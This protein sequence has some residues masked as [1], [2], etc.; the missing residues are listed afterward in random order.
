[1]S[2]RQ[3]N[4]D[5]ELSDIRA[6]IAEM[7]LRIDYFDALLS[8]KYIDVMSNMEKKLTELHHTMQMM[9]PPAPKKKCVSCNLL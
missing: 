5:L 8:T 7:K 2:A 3:E 9:N 6:D 4:I 1:M